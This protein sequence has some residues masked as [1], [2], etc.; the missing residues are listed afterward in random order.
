MLSLVICDD[1]PEVLETLRQMVSANLPHPAPY[2][3]DTFSSSEKLTKA[4]R[5]GLQ[6][7]IALIDIKFGQENG[8]H[9]AK[10]LFP[11]GSR[12]QVIFVTGYIEYCT[13]VYETE[14]I[15]FLVKPVNGQELQQALRKALERLNSGPEKL[16]TL[17]S[18]TMIQRIPLSAIRYIESRARKVIIYYGSTSYEHYSTLTDLLN[19]LPENFIHCH[20]SFCVNME[21]IVR[22]EPDRFILS[23]EKTI[24]ISQ[25]KRTETR[26][27][28]L[29]FLNRGL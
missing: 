21:H 19:Q 20:K 28:F 6:P 18:R 2:R 27:R 13:A 11:L 24:P 9:L 29:E 12:T 15:Y 14:H 17:R 1:S 25:T 5:K 26:T 22:M 3:I 10:Q 23:D 16:L 7:D 8:I 4:V